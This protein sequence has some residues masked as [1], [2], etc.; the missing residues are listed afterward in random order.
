MIEGIDKRIVVVGGGPTGLYCAYLLKKL[1]PNIIVTVIEKQKECG[2]PFCCSG[3][4]D[5]VGYNRLKIKNNLVLKDFLVNKVYG[6]H[7]NGPIEAKFSVVSKDVKAYVID[8]EK[9]DKSI[10]NLA[11]SF[12]VEI[13]NFSQVVSLKDNFLTIKNLE[14][15]EE[16]EIRYDFLVGADGPNS[17]VRKTFFPNIVNEDFLHTYQITAKGVFDDKNVSVFLSDY[18]KGL[19]SWIV[20]ESKNVAKIGIGVKLGKNPKE[21]FLKVKEKFK[22]KYS[23]VTH[24]CSGILPISKPI[25]NLIYKN[26][27][28]VGDAACFV[29]STTGGGINFG[30]L[31]SQEAARAINDYIKEYKNL[32]NYNNYLKEYRKELNLHYKIRKYFYSKDILSQDKLLLKLK[33]VGVIDVLEKHGTMDYPSLFIKK[34]FL[35]RKIYSLIPEFF[36]FIIK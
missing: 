34:C 15:L 23:D 29:K 24:Q 8:R 22:I 19:F 6:C 9:F 21:M 2:V 11:K 1:N 20:P 10:E 3:L 7:I 4:I 33:D 25:K 27:L 16:K 32:E 35:N 12:G 28:L 30:L 26:V 17:I 5:V 36:K 14:T 31:S 18:S 13:L